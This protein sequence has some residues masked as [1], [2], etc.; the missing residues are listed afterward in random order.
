MSNFLKIYFWQAISIVFNFA[1]VFVITPYISSNQALFGIYS[2]ITAAYLFI[3]Y[4]DFGFLSAGMKYAS[5]SYAKKDLKE[6]IEVIGFTG[7]VF[8][9]FAIIYALILI[10]ISFIPHVIIKSSNN[11]LE[12]TIARHLLIILALSCPIFVIQRIIQ[13]IYSVRLQDYKFQRILTASSVIK[14][15]GA[16]L[17]FSGGKYLI[18]EYFLFSQTCTLCAVLIGLFI[19]QKKIK[20]NLR[21][22]VASFKLSTKLYQKT[23]KLAFT[24]ILLTTSWI[25]YYELDPFVISKILGSKHV[26]IYAIGLATITYFRT[27]FGIFF[28]PFI[29]KFNHFVG[30]NDTEGLRIFFIKIL[31]L[32]FPVTVFPVITVALTTKNF[33]LSWVG[34]NYMNSIPITQT[35]VLSYIF[36]FIMSP[37]GIL[38]M[39]NE[40]VKALYFT[41][42]IQPIIYWTGI[43]IF[44]Q[45]WGLQTFA[46]FKFI[47]FL[48]ETVIYITLVLR[49]L[50]INFLTFLKKIV[51][52][53]ILPLLT[54]II[55]VL[56]VRGYLPIS[57]SKINLMYYFLVNGCIILAGV[58]C[59]Y[60]TSII[61]KQ[62][63]NKLCANI[64][65]K[66]SKLTLCL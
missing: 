49:F 39:A 47:A 23:K 21:L 41:S 50:Q 64:F 27:L 13:I 4:A 31:I 9:I 14:V 42:V 2:I 63:T 36:I 54:I 43:L 37:S 53:T 61:F 22:L 26:A 48:G 25:L 8:F 6:E 20:Y 7:M 60:F 30:L 29:A 32:F 56:A 15:A 17:F 12:L 24:S 18:V 45:Y 57:K 34:P 59:Y 38:I 33:I 55:L 65:S 46:Y 51:P 52:P 10:T 3:S 58:I 44:F 1:S 16:I 40:R 19:L 66:R 11:I 5:E 35:L 62:H 28:T